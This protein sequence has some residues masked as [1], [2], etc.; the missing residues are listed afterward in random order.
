[1]SR[2][3]GGSRGSVRGVAADRPGMYLL[4]QSLPPSSPAAAGS[5]VPQLGGY[6]TEQVWVVSPR[7]EGPRVSPRPGRMRRWGWGDPAETQALE[8]SGV[9]QTHHTLSSTET[10][11]GTLVALGLGLNGSRFVVPYG[12]GGRE[13]WGPLRSDTWSS[14][15]SPGT[16]CQRPEKWYPVAGAG[17]VSS[18]WPRI[19]ERLFHWRLKVNDRGRFWVRNRG[20]EGGD[21]EDRGGCT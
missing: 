11:T 7:K 10:P 19:P 20:C 13:R 8:F 21:R 15:T 17:R 18:Q 6:G 9:P 2:P 12:W 14:R 4:H 16:S 1:M 5:F 3:G